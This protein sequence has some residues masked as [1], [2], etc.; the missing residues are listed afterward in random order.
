[1]KHAVVLKNASHTTCRFHRRKDLPYFLAE[2]GQRE[3]EERFAET[4]GVVY[5]W[6]QYPE[7]M[8]RYSEKYCWLTRT[9]DPYLHDVAIYH[10]IKEKN[11]HFFKRSRAHEVQ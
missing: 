6:N 3:H 7:E 5:Y 4:S 1:L 10:D 9:F 11:G 8:R 2:E